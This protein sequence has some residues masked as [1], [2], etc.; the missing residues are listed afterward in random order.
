MTSEGYPAIKVRWN[1]D[2]QIFTGY[3]ELNP[4]DEEMVKARFDRFKDENLS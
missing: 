1:G 4:F 3:D 2:E